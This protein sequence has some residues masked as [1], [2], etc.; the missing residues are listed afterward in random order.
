M[1][2]RPDLEVFAKAHGIKIG[3]VAD[4]IHYRLHNEPTVERVA[5]CNMPTAH[6]DFQL[7]AYRDLLTHEMHLALVKGEFSPE[8]PT[9]VRVHMQSTLCDLFGNQRDCGWPL[10]DALQRIHEEGQGVVIIL[11]PPESDE[12]MIRQIQDYEMED[13]GVPVPEPEKSEDLRT[14]GIGAQILLDLGIGKMRVL[15]SPKKMH[16]LSGFGL[17]V[18]EYIND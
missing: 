13:K 11:R 2:R 1:A 17:D 5:S 4:L 9:L 8:Q 15:S 14:Y 16:A 10:S 3:T 12:R 6:G 7:L 18:V